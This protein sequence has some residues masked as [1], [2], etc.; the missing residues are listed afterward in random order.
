MHGRLAT[1]QYLASIEVQVDHTCSLCDRETETLE[2][3]FFRCEFA[4]AV[5]NGVW[6]WCGFHQTPH[7][8]DEEQRVL[9]VH[10]SS[11]NGRQRLYRCVLTVLV[12]HLWMERN[13]RRMQGKKRAVEAIVY[14]CQLLVAWCGLKD[15]K[16][17][18]CLRRR[19]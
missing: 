14:Q 13:Q 4:A 5:W 6:E 16:L 15:R 19:G 10:C 17:G 3:L 11:N 8:W 7:G 18:R 1:C 9:I 12:Y 2:H